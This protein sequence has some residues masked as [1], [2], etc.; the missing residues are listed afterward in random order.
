MVISTDLKFSVSV[1]NLFFVIGVKI[2]KKKDFDLKRREGSFLFF[3]KTG[4]CLPR[5]HFSK[6]F[7][8]PID[9]FFRIL[10][11]QK[12]VKKQKQTIFR[13]FLFAFFSYNLSKHL[14]TINFYFCKKNG[15]IIF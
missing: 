13:F 1:K 9:C 2:D 11:V 12:T 14:K 15:R 8:F 4:S 3:I 7:P 10:S 5:K 6:K